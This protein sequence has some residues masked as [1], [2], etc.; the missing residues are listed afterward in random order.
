M[1]AVA[2]MM[3][4]IT[5]MNKAFVIITLI[6]PFLIGGVAVLPGLLTASGA[7]TPDRIEVG[8]VSSVPG[9]SGTLSGELERSPVVIR[10]YDSRAAADEAVREKEISGYL[11]ASAPPGESESYTYYSR[12]GTDVTAAEA[13]EQALGTIATREKL[14][15]LGV[16]PAVLEI[17]NDT[18]QVAMKKLG[19]EEESTGFMMVMFTS[20]G[21]VMLLYMTVLL[22]GQMIGRSVVQEKTN[23]T[24]EIMLSSVRPWQLMYG[25]IFGI[26]L[27]GLLQYAVWFSLAAAVLTVLGSLGVNTPELISSRLFG[28][29]LL[30]FL[31]AYLLYAASFAAIGAASEDEQHLGQLSTPFIIFLVIPLVLIGTLVM[32]PGS[33][34]SQILSY[35]PM[36]AP[37]VMFIRVLVETPAIWEILLSYVIVL[38]TI[39]LIAGVG[40]KIFRI[41]ILLT[42][43]RPSM[44]EVLGWMK[45]T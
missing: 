32:N 30:Y 8:M 22:Y 27:A 36:T 20:I 6:G 38:A 5:A 9:F 26:G 3:F 1:Y 23:K 15:E 44:R 12:T 14:E 35:F 40:G 28:I 11:L 17:L 16:D 19:G 24:V 41:G 42:G 45:Q 39:V 29:L 2:K 10:Q 37:I 43:K 18:P 25:K 13:L 31:P 21:F 34:I 4:R 7:G 33:L